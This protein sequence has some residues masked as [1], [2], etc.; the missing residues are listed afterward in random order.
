MTTI[1]FEGLSPEQAGTLLKQ[2]IAEGLS[3]RVEGTVV[4]GEA[5]PE[6]EE[7]PKRRGRKPK[8]TKPKPEPKA[9]EDG[10]DDKLTEFQAASTKEQK[11]LIDAELAVWVK[12]KSNRPWL[13]GLFDDHDATNVQKLDPSQY[14]SFYTELI[15]GPGNE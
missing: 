14:E 10:E 11:K 6:P 1:T 8:A 3:A 15:K 5:E 2:A 4:L 13:K 12:D 7:K 9:D